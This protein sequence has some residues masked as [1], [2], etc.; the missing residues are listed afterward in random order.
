MQVSPT[1]VLETRFIES[2]SYHDEVLTS[3]G[4]K[5]T[6][7]NRECNHGYVSMNAILL[8]GIE[9]LSV[10]IDTRPIY[11]LVTYSVNGVVRGAHTA[12]G[13]N[14]HE[15]SYDTCTAISDTFFE[16]HITNMYGVPQAIVSYT[17]SNE[18]IYTD[19]FHHPHSKYTVTKTYRMLNP[20]EWGPSRTETY[21]EDLPYQYL[22]DV[23]G[24]P[25]YEELELIRSYLPKHASGILVHN[26]GSTFVD[27]L[28]SKLALPNVNNF[29][30]L[31]D[32]KEIRKQLPP[33]LKLLRRHNFKTLAEFWLW[34]RYSYS[35]SKLDLK[36][37]WKFF[38]E[39][40]KEKDT[41][42]GKQHIAVRYYNNGISD[43]SSTSEVTT[44]HCYCDTFHASVWSCL[45]LDFNLSNTWDLIPFSFVVDWFINLNDILSRLDATDVVSELRVA[46]VVTSTKRVQVSYPLRSFGCYAQCKVVDYRRDVG[47]KLPVGNIALSLKNPASHIRDGAALIV[48]RK[49]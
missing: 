6:F 20:E 21:T 27:D 43:S 7:S 37:Y 45:G 44:V 38:Q 34:Y 14:A 3:S 40:Q 46:S 4:A 35:T 19:E 22:G 17:K 30:N 32:L 49:R 8:N 42:H 23:S 48:A 9:G 1:G 26:I 24:F 2:L 10:S 15:H 36:A 29:E 41:V 33:L 13:R 25:T 18:T 16:E 12:L 39:V 5:D 31:K 28:Y 47:G 11:P